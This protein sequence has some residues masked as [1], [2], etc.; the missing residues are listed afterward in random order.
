V[1]QILQI[2]LNILHCILM[3]FDQKHS[4]GAHN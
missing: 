4:E 3:I 1:P 2:Q